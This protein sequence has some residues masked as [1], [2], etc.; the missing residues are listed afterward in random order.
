MPVDAAQYA[1]ISCE[2]LE[3][4]DFLQVKHKHQ[5]YL[6]KPPLLFWLSTFSFYLF[7]ISDFAY[8]LPSFLFSII[9][10]FATYQL[11][12]RLYD[13]KI[14]W[15]AV[16]ILA[17]CQAWF[18]FN[19]DV[20]TDTLL[21]A[22]V[23]TAIW[24]LVAYIDTEKYKYLVGSSFFLALAML[25]KGPIGLMLPVLAL[26][27]HFLLKRQWHIFVKWQW[28]L[29]FALVMLF[30]SPML[31]GLYQQFGWHGIQFYF[32]E[33][34]FGRITGGNVWK[35][36]TSYLF[37]LH[38]FLWAF[39]PF[40]LWALAAVT[41]NTYHLIKNKFHS[42]SL[43]EAITLGGTIL[44]FAVLS[45]SQYKLPHYIFVC[46]PLIAILT[47]VFITDFLSEKTAK[48]KTKKIAIYTQITI[49]FLLWIV[50]LSFPI[51]VFPTTHALFWAITIFVFAVTC[52]YSFTSVLPIKK[53]ILTS[54][55]T[56]I[57][58]NFILNA[59]AYQELKKYESGYQAA[60][61]I[62]VFSKKNN[63][64]IY[65][66]QISNQSFNYYIQDIPTEL[67]T[68]ENLALTASQKQDI[69]IY[70]N[71]EGVEKL[72]NV[73]P[74][75]SEVFALNHVHVTKLKIGFFN[76]KTRGKYTNVRYLVKW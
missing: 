36:E 49:N 11:A 31:L 8:R 62:S 58:I 43:H 6:D 4:G 18:L 57:G 55:F 15:I 54:V 76:P 61:L 38:T 64:K 45:L 13:K 14:G 46:F 34:S 16:L 68:P 42:N 50:A 75:L 35:D 69:W 39:L 74:E 21:A 1:S 44:P 5:D 24:Q 41:K 67:E 33:Q 53:L 25:S 30:L 47:A 10:L 7:G 37:F 9:G 72:K 70:T 28:L 12:Q 2:M 17:H 52:Y 56:A 27:S 26:G 22:S 40:T 63:A 65:T 51:F 29:V 66:Y 32:W 71:K 3:N 73:K 59:H 60:D 19:H 23:I 48:L 20:R